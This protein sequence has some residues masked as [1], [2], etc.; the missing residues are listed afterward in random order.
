MAL[1]P[2]GHI[3]SSV[4]IALD[5]TGPRVMENLRALH[6]LGFARLADRIEKRILTVDITLEGG[7]LVVRAP[8]NETFLQGSFG[9]KGRYFDRTRK[10]TVVAASAK[11]ELWSLLR[12]AYPGR[13]GRGPKGMFQI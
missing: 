10:A 2:P 6:A 8:Y 13:T 1:T 12:R 11:P 3:R 9:L 7:S 4:T 5:Q